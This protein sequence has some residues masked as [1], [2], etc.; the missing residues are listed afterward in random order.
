MKGQEKMIVDSIIERMAALVILKTE[1]D[2][3]VE[4]WK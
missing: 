3:R 2:E 4:K 1:S